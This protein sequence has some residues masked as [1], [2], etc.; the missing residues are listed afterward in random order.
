[1]TRKISATMPTYVDVS[2]GDT[3][4]QQSLMNVDR[5]E[6]KRESTCCDQIGVQRARIMQH[7]QTR[8]C[9]IEL[10]N[11]RKQYADAR[12][13]QRRAADSEFGGSHYQ[14]PRGN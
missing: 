12:G 1:M 7:N 5:S 6:A 13:G 4:P 10:T 9:S 3:P 14:A 2:G 8:P 11:A